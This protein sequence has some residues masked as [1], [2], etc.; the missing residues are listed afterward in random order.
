LRLGVCNANHCIPRRELALA[1]IEERGTRVA[2]NYC[3]CL[4]QE[5]SGAPGETRTPAFWF[6]GIQYKTLSAA[7]GVACETPPTDPVSGELL[8]RR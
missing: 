6:V 1:E 4:I 8:F 3:K 2:Q 5:I 7:S